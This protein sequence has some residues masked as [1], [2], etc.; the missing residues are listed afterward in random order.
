MPSAYPRAARGTKARA[1]TLWVLYAAAVSVASAGL[2]APDAARLVAGKV[3]YNAVAPDGREMP[4][5]AHALAF[6]SSDV[7]VVGG[8]AEGLGCS[9]AWAF[10]AALPL[11]AA[12]F[13]PKANHAPVSLQMRQACVAHDYCYRHGAAT[14]GYTQADCDGVLLEQAM[15]LCV[16]IEAARRGGGRDKETARQVQDECR[17]RARTIVLGVRV[18]GAGSFKRADWMAD[19]AAGGTS[20]GVDARASTYFEYDP[21]PVHAER[22]TVYRLADAPGAGPADSAVPRARRKALYV[23]RMRPSGAEVVVVGLGGAGL[24]G[25]AAARAPEILAAHRLGGLHAA[26]TAP[27]VVARAGSGEDWIVWWQRASLHGTGGRLVAIAPGRAGPADWAQTAA[28]FPAAPNLADCR[29]VGAPEGG[30]SPAAAVVYLGKH[31]EGVPGWVTNR[32][33][34]AEFSELHPVPGLG[35]GAS[36]LRFVALRTHGCRAGHANLCFLRIAVDVSNGGGYQP[37]EPMRADDRHGPE[38]VPESNRYRNFSSAPFAFGDPSDPV[39]AWLRRGDGARGEGFAASTDIRRQT[40]VG[41]SALKDQ[42]GRSVGSATLAKLDQGHEPVFVVGRAGLTPRIV[43]LRAGNPEAGHAEARGSAGPVA[44]HQWLL[45]A[46]KTDPGGG[47][48]A[49]RKHD[50][51]ARDERTCGIKIDRSWFARPASVLARPNGGALVFMSRLVP[52]AP[53]DAAPGSPGKGGS[54]DVALRF[55]ALRI[56]ADGTCSTAPDPAPPVPARRLELAARDSGERR[57]PVDLLAALRA[58]PVLVDDVDAD[59][60]PDVVV[61]R[62]DRPEASFVHFGTASPD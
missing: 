61:P 41:G 21:Y 2:L 13:P 44:V 51:V 36:I 52:A 47:E 28:P 35:A 10:D 1:A 12:V 20:A 55:A 29:G 4:P 7:Q 54:A 27:P 53:A 33:D 43:G 14:Y 37:Q 15:R 26:I 30:G 34:D 45:P 23:F 48:K 57:R 8:R 19:D 39:V 5:V 42:T 24:D 17:P 50:T 40:V 9:I 22:Y 46:P 18:G 62:S 3:Y 38:V 31:I 32:C 49:P 25:G 59:E 6:T 16:F 56:G 60:I 11:E 58:R